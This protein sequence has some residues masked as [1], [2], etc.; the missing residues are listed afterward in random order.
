MGKKMG[1]HVFY[2][3]LRRSYP[4]LVKGDGVYLY[5]DDGRRYIDGSSGALVCSLGHGNRE[6]A[7][8]MQQ[9]AEKLA[10]APIAR[11][12]HGPQAELA[13]RLAKMG[14]VELP[15]SYFVSGGSEA[16]E[17][18]V[19]MARQY[20]LERGGTNVGRFLVIGRWPSYHGNTLGCLSVGGH[21]S[22]RTPYAPYLMP[23]P[24]IGLPNCGSCS[25]HLTRSTCDLR[26]VDALER[27][28]LKAGPQNVSCF[29]METIT[30][31]C[32]GVIL[33]PPD[34]LQRV[35]AICRRY[36]IVFVAD[37]IMCGAGRTGKFLA[38]SHFGQMPDIL[39]L[40]KGIAAGYSAL[41]AL[42]VSERVY[43]AFEQGSGA[44]V[45]N[46]TY[47]ANPLSCATACKVLDILT[48]DRLIDRS[49]EA[50]RRL[51]EKL[52]PLTIRHHVL[53]T[54]IRGIGLMIALELYQNR[55]SQISFPPESK[56]SEKLARACLDEGLVIYPGLLALAD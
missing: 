20:H 13:E 14:S 30:G 45:N 34:Y 46:Y 36:D 15:Y 31:S 18:A 40:G 5:D 2:R 56:I 29:I 49:A 16:V 52:R 24:K 3:D 48:R 32:G 41:A 39:I 44:F 4:T 27:E 21:A 26:C 35:A 43:E 10:F 11:F 53:G 9:Q 50:G 55:D 22:R 33:P 1:D 17:T 7:E 19:K 38:S 37:E 28:I 25:W 6:V 8:F 42:L 47:A 51:R 54:D 23:S 12:T